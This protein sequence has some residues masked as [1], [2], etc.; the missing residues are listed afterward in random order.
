MG[1]KLTYPLDILFKI[2]YELKKDGKRICL[3]H[4]AFDLFHDGHLYLIN[5]SAKICD[6]LIVGIEGDKRIAEYKE[7]KRPIISQKQ[8]IN[9]I[10]SIEN[11]DATFVKDI[12]FNVG[13]HADLYKEL[14]VDIV[15]I[16][17]FFQYEEIVKEQASKAGAKLS[18]IYNDR[19]VSTTSIID[20]IIK[21]YSPSETEY[22]EVPKTDF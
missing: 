10:N 3:T 19:G 20:T 7:K 13:S 1:T 9:L 4:G 14:K 11:V 22:Q 5:Q 6:Y 17:R 18:K 2:A 15:T 21:K 16:G 12:P 8:R